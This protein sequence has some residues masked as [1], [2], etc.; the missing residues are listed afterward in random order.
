MALH[1]IGKSKILICA[2]SFKMSYATFAPSL[3]KLSPFLPPA[4]HSLIKRDH[5]QTIILITKQ[6]QAPICNYW[7]QH[8][9]STWWGEKVKRFPN[10][11]GGALVLGTNICTW[12]LVVRI[13]YFSITLKWTLKRSCMQVGWV[14]NMYWRTSSVCLLLTN[15][16]I[17]INTCC[18]KCTVATNNM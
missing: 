11:L 16:I 2:I 8:L 10:M 9:S 15:M 18:E 1:K 3:P 12:L 14:E 5:K 17:L 7:P 4:F 13:Y 6:R